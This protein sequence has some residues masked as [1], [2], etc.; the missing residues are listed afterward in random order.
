V[1]VGRSHELHV[2]LVVHGRRVCLPLRP[3]CKKCFLNDLCETGKRTVNQNASN[4]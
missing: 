2:G 1:P 3:L 4:A